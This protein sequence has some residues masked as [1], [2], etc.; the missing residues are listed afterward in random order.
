MNLSVEDK[1]LLHLA[2]G[3]VRRS[4]A[5][6][7][8]AEKDYEAALALADT[9]HNLLDSERILNDLGTL[10]F[11]LTEYDRALEYYNKA[12]DVLARIASGQGTSE[13]DLFINM[14]AVSAKQ[15]RGPLADEYL[16]RATLLTELG[17]LPWKRAELSTILENYVCECSTM[18]WP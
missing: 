14:A 17:T 18:S 1:I 7:E 16:Q 9:A 4:L 6:Y 3:L 10:Y 11:L 5:D 12:K 8:K 2:R 15:G 13:I